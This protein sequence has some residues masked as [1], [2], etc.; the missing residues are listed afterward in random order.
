MEDLAA[1]ILYRPRHEL[2]IQ[3][4]RQ[5]GI[6]MKFISDGDVAVAIVTAKP[7]TSIDIMLGIG[8]ASEGV[9]ASVVLRYLGA[10]WK[11]A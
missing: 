8:G 6:R 3:G 4:V 7:E 10:I 9:L 2:L 5:A 1:V 11:P